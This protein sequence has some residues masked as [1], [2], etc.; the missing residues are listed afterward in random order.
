MSSLMIDA[1]KLISY[2]IWA[3]RRLTEQTTTFATDLFSKKLGGSF[4]SIQLT[5]RHL[6]ESDW[7]WMHRWQGIPYV[8]VPQTWSTDDAHSIITTWTPIQDQIKERIEALATNPD[9][10]IVF[11]TKKGDTF[12]LPFLDTV[13]HSTNH[14]SYHRGQIVNM[15]R[16]LGEKPVNTDY[17]I[18]CTLPD[19]IRA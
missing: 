8:E 10:D 7:I 2:N 12:R 18:F 6:V 19:S 9:E 17:F 15:I 16:M 11:A 1:V 4:P 13:I 5:L 3:N 14:G